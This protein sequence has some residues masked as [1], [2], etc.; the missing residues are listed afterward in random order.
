MSETEKKPTVHVTSGG[1]VWVDANEQLNTAKAR[2]TIE[3]MQQWADKIK[4]SRPV[5]RSKTNKSNEL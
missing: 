5:V 3:K 1:R 2:E 4:I